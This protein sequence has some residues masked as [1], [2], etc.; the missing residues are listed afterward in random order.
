M[1]RMK[2]TPGS[3]FRLALTQENPLQ[4]VG[5][6]NAF[7]SL[8]AKNAGFKALYLSGAAVA[9][10]SFALPDLGMV[11]LTA[12][13]EEVRRIT[14]TT[15]LPLLVDADTAGS[16]PL[17]VERTITGLIQAGAAACHIEDQLF[18]KRCGHRRNKKLCSLS[19][20]VE[21]I[22]AAVSARNQQTHDPD[23]FIMARTDALAS[24]GLAGAIAR[25][26]AYVKAGADGIFAEALT[27]WEQYQQFTAAIDVP[28]LANLTE[29]GVSPLLP[30]TKYQ[31]AKI[32]ML[33]YPLSAFR[34]MSKAAEGVYTTIR[35][36]GNQQNVLSSMQTRDELYQLLDYSAQEQRLDDFYARSHKE[37]TDDED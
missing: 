2:K 32:A 36:Q 37:G 7:A 16:Q 8:Q 20:M 24:E 10:A 12:L 22:K 23:F 25:A 21:R 4:I 28:V 19:T 33:L 26:Q 34:A 5:V 15:D 11:D 3:E 27:T 17:M 31:E 29:F 35:S 1:S 30:L 9:N 14:H 13:L 6:I 18:F